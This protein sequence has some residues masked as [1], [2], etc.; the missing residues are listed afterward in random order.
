MAYILADS[1]SIF[2]KAF[3]PPKAHKFERETQNFGG[4]VL[5][6][7]KKNPYSFRITT[8][9]IFSSYHIIGHNHNNYNFLKCDWC[10][11][12]CIFL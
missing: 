11:N 1:L 7:L 5:S 4:C 2:V 8:A 10:I 3:L 6:W 12:C 9:V